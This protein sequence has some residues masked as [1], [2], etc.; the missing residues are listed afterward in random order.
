M[1]TLT[2]DVVILNWPSDRQ[3]PSTAD[4]RASEIVSFMGVESVVIGWKGRVAPCVEGGKLALNAD[5]GKSERPGRGERD[6]GAR[7]HD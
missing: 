6:E 1:A 5:A 4:R 7:V 3:S 2:S